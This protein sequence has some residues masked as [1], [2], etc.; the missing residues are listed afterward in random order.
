M[1][2]FT[3]NHGIRN[4]RRSANSF[5]VPHVKGFGMNSFVYTSSK[6]WNDLPTNIKLINNKHTFKNAV[7]KLYF[8]QLCSSENSQYVYM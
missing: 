6:L 1:D 7:K 5:I 4:T 2:S 3:V 8:D